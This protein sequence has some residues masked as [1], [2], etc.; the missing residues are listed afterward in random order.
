MLRYGSVFWLKSCPRRSDVGEKAYVGILIRRERRG[1][2]DLGSTM[3]LIL[4]KTILLP[5]DHE[6]HLVI[7]R[8]VYLLMGG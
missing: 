4:A 5:R 1:E 3:L 7:L 8:C 2:R 6:G